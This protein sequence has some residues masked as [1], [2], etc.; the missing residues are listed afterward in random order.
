MVFFAVL[1][2]ILVLG[3]MARRP[4]RASYVLVALGTVAASVYEYLK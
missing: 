1:G 4:S 2:L 3:V